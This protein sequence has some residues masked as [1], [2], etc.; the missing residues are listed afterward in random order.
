VE[1][2]TPRDPQTN[3][4]APAGDVIES[5]TIEVSDSS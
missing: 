2:L 1:A 5:V 3:P 4:D